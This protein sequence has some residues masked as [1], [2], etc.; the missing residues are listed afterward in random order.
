MP[1][2]TSGSPWRRGPGRS[3]RSSAFYALFYALTEGAERALVADL[4]PASSR[5][6]AFGAYH[7]GV[8]LAALPASLLFGIWWKAYGPHVAFLIGAAIAVVA[9]LSLTAW[10]LT[11]STASGAP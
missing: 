5:G 4:V 7:G 2:R 9:A 1:W 3:G 8:G 6:R 11:S 10:R